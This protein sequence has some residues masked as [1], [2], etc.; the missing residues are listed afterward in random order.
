MFKNQ[1]IIHQWLP[2]AGRG[3]V[4]DYK[5]DAQANIEDDQTVLYGPGVANSRFFAFVKTRR[6]AQ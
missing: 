3:G 6:T 2:G 5:G 1:L 4:V